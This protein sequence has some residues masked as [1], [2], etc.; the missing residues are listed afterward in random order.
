MCTCNWRFATW[1]ASLV[2]KGRKVPAYTTVGTVRHQ[3]HGLERIYQ[4]VIGP[5]SVSQL[6]NRQLPPKR[7]FVTGM[8]EMLLIYQYISIKMQPTTLTR[9]TRSLFSHSSCLFPASSGREKKNHPVT[10]P[11][12][13]GLLTTSSRAAYQ[14]NGREKKTLPPADGVKLPQFR[15]QPK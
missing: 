14:K 7:P 8:R 12:Q 2:P 9:M 15:G 3:M 4:P 6:H 5:V 11:W 1:S 13:D 10:L